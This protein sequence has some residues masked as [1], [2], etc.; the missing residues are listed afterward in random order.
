MSEVRKLESLDEVGVMIDVASRLAMC[1]FA[2]A[3][4]AEFHSSIFDALEEMLMG[5]AGATES[6]RGIISDLRRGVKL[7]VD[8][9]TMSEEGE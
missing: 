7:V 1:A 4:P 5:E 2:F 9:K 6:S 3:V 8:L